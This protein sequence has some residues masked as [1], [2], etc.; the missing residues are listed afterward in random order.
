MSKEIYLDH[1]DRIIE[2]VTVAEAADLM[3][4]IPELQVIDGRSIESYRQGHLEGA[5]LFDAFNPDTGVEL[6]QL[7][8]EVPY[9]VYCTTNVRSTMIVQWMQQ[10]DFKKIYHMVEG[11][12]GW[13]HSNQ[14]IVS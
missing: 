3:A 7:D 14:H 2:P 13:R 8:R 1:N 5:Q 12:V 11:M 4:S 9:L 10:S 6:G